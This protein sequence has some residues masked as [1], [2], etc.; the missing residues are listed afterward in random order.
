M[1]KLT[2]AFRKFVN[3]PTMYVIQDASFIFPR[4]LVEIPFNCNT[5]LAGYVR[6]TAGGSTLN[7]NVRNCS[8]IKQMET[9]C[10]QNALNIGFHENP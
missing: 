3:A 7:R 1:T 5:H 8:A 10:A 9:K 2:V 6:A 4:L